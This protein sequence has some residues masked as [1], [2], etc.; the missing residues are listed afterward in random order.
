MWVKR[1]ALVLLIAAQAAVIEVGA[2][3]AVDADAAI[4]TRLE[5]IERVLS[6]QGL[7]E[8]LQ[9]MGTLEEEISGL[10]GELEVQNHALEQIKK[11]QRDLYRDIDRRLQRFETPL[12]TAIGEAAGESEPP[13][14]T[15][16]PITETEVTGTEQQDEMTLTLELVG[17]EPEAGAT[18][19]NIVPLT[20]PQEPLAGLEGTGTAADP[21]QDMTPSEAPDG[22]SAALPVSVDPGRIQTD[23]QNAFNLLKQS[24]Y[25]RSITA[26]REFLAS[27]PDSEYADKA[28]FWLGE[29]Y[30]M[31]RLFDQALV[32]YNALLQNYP[33]SRKLAQAQLKAGFCQLELG[34]IEPAKQQLE[35]L[36]QQ[37]PGTT[38]AHLAQDRLKKIATVAIPA[39]MTPV[40]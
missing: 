38:A 30:Y 17:Q 1:Q 39:D 37:H 5:N 22:A 21:A 32:E 24:R 20:T 11:R 12:T 19:E 28:Q 29:A 23:Y 16:S 4:L 34:Q 6:N 31:N 13:L 2:E 10:R 18:G 3:D 9:Q 8:M 7:L 15:L 26:F 25:D 27:Y 40:N 35:D 14:Q 33:D 36:I